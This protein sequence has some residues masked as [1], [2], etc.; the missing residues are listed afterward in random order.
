MFRNKLNE[1]PEREITAWLDKRGIP[2]DRYERLLPNEKSALNDSLH[3]PSR[4]ISYEQR[5]NL[6]RKLCLTEVAGRGSV[7]PVNF[8]PDEELEKF[9]TPIPPS[10]TL[11]DY[12]KF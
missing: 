5:K 9:F 4:P 7:D 1:I 12:E 2:S 6:Y 8:L 11:L 3:I 10:E